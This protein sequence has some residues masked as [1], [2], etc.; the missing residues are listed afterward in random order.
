[1]ADILAALMIFGPFAVEN[2]F[3]QLRQN[4]SGLGPVMVD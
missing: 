1:M 3:E 2:T 4:I